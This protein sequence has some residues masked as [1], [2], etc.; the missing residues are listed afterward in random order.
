MNQTRKTTLTVAGIVGAFVVVVLVAVIA[1]KGGKNVS[2]STALTNLFNGSAVTGNA[3]FDQHLANPSSPATGDLDMAAD[4]KDR[5]VL[6]RSSVDGEGPLS[7]TS[8]YVRHSGDGGVTWDVAVRLDNPSGVGTADNGIA[9]ATDGSDRVHVV[10]GDTRTSSSHVPYFVRS[11][12]AGATWS[13]P[14]AISKSARLG[15]RTFK[16]MDIIADLYGNVTIAWEDGRA[17]VADT[18]NI[19]V[20]NSS[21]Y[22]STLSGEVKVDS[23]GA[24]VSKEIGPNL[25]YGKTGQPILMWR[26]DRSSASG[27]IMTAYSSNGGLAWSTEAQADVGVSAAIDRFRMCSDE[28]GGAHV[29]IEASGGVAH[30]SSSV[31]FGRSW[32]APVEVTGASTRAS[33]LEAQAASCAYS[34]DGLHRAVYAFAGVEGIVA[35]SLL[36]D[37]FVTVT[38]NGGTTWSEPVRLDTSTTTAGEI[39]AAVDA[40]GRMVVGWTGKTGGGTATDGYYNYSVDSGVS[41]QES[42]SRFTKG[43]STAERT[44]KLVGPTNTFD[45][46][47]TRDRGVFDFAY[48]DTIGDGSGPGLYYSPVEIESAQRAPVRAA[49]ATR[50][51]TGLEA[52]RQAFPVEGT[53]DVVVIAT[54]INFPDALAGGPAAAA[55]NGTVLL[56][57][58]SELDSAVAKEIVRLLE[59]RVDDGPEIIV[60]GGEAALS[61]SVF[62]ALEALDPSYDVVRA[63]GS[64]RTETAVALAELIDTYRGGPAPAVAL[65]VK[66]NFPDA[67]AAGVIQADPEV[68]PQFGRVLMTATN[69]L[70]TATADYLR[71]VSGTT[72]HVDLFGGTAV[73]TDTLFDQVKEIIPSVSRHFGSNRY[74]TANAAALAF[75]GDG[76]P[77]APQGLTITTGES[78]PDALTCTA[79]SARDSRPMILTR[80]ATVPEDVLSYVKDHAASLYKMR[81]CG[82]E[83][84]VTKAV[85]NVLGGSY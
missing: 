52:S 11:V 77:L 32:S 8:L 38:D 48:F 85:E 14:V 82:G 50:I 39:G 72:T 15:T 53:A 43:P 19:Y 6:Y 2:T 81:I 33:G 66:S 62:T 54:S 28:L 7:G 41:W 74:G 56:T 5:W 34:Y 75:Y 37:V 30:I 4:G 83:A 40:D 69:S 9:I 47:T 76:T 55:F 25:A 44:I 13:T 29:F 78:F 1:I 68:S 59:E 17:D 58:P 45:S 46:A 31:D 3:S 27:D 23:V 51:E 16:V 67:L 20:V 64:S 42:E 60:A 80:T 73:L 35:D 10:W 63:S 79:L 70:D 84:A 18:S 12:D 65:A 21:D 61:A 22:G 71:S 26:S 49:G 36:R 24:G 57:S